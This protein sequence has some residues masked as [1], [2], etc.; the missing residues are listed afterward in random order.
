MV[1]SIR[2]YVD[3]RR[4]ERVAPS[5]VDLLVSSGETLHD[6]LERL[7]TRPEK[8]VIVVDAVGRLEGVLDEAGL[9]GALLATGRLDAR[10]SNLELP[11]DCAIH[12]DTPFDEVVGNTLA[13]GAA[14]VPVLDD[15][16]RVIN[17][18]TRE[19]LH[20]WL[21]EDLPWDPRS[22]FTARGAGERPDAV[23]RPWGFYRSLLTTAF[24]QAKILSVAPGQELSLQKHFHREEY[25][26]VVRGEGSFRLDDDRYTV[27]RGFTIHIPREAVH[28]IR[29]T[30]ASEALI[31][32]EVQVG[33]Y[34]GED[35]IVRLSDKYHR[36]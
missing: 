14:L 34:F 27:R 11:R 29:N 17:A 25:W 22:D 35:D 23:T 18:F 2:R 10:L 13:T 12:V 21:A 8:A 33:D 32:V 5:V 19:Q 6:A 9:R 24:T 7:H 26:T 1:E 15:R 16:E 20:Q 3:E 31:L 28:W 36:A 4:I 30:H